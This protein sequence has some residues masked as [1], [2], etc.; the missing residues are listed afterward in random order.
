LL[1]GGEGIAVT[2]YV[3]GGLGLCVAAV[4]LA[5]F[6]FPKPPPLDFAAFLGGHRRLIASLACI[7]VGGAVALY[8]FVAL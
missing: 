8:G 7:V 4:G 5:L 1:I 3:V 2:G 6:A